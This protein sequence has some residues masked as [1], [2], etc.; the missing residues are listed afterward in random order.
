VKNR[1]NILLLKGDAALSAFREQALL[2]RLSTVQPAINA[3]TAQRVYFAA[4]TQTPNSAP[5]PTAS[6]LRTLENLLEAS[7]NG[8][9]SQVKPNPD[10]TTL[11]V[12]PR[13]GTISPWSSRATEIARHCGLGDCIERIE[14]GV[15][16]QLTA[17]VDVLDASSLESLV[18]MLHDRMT[19]S[20]LTDW[21]EIAQLFAHSEPAPM[22][23]INIKSKDGAQELTAANKALGL[24]LSEAEI[25][26]V[27]DI[28][29]KAGRAPSDVELMMF[30]QA[31]SE[32]CRHKIF[33]A[34]WVIDT[35]PQTRTLFQMIRATH[36]AQPEG[37][38]VA[39]ADNAAVIEGIPTER[40]Y[41]LTEGYRYRRETTHLVAKVETHNHPTAISPFPGAAT[42]AGGEIRDEGATGRGARPKAGLCGF[43]VS[44]LRI[45]E[46]IQPW[47]QDQIKPSHIAS[48]LEIMIAGP[49][50]AAAFNNEFGRPNL[51]GCFRTYEKA[52]VE[53][54]CVVGYYGY[55]K[56]VMLAGGVGNVASDH[57][58]KRDRLPP[59]VPLVV[60]GGPGMLIGLGGG[61]ASSLDA[62]GNT[63]ELD[64]ASVQRGNPEMQRRAQ[65]VIEQC[66]ALGPDNP[67][68]SIHDVGAGGLANAFPELAHGG[69]AG[70]CFE[71][72]KLPVEEPGM[73]PAEIWCNESQERYVLAIDDQHLEIFSSLCRRERCP[74]AVAGKTTADG[75][76]QL[77]D[78]H[79][80]N[81]PVDMPLEQ[82]L[83]KLPRQRRE[84]QRAPPRVSEIF[85]VDGLDLHEATRRVF[86]LPGVADKAF[87][88]TIGDRSVGGLT[89]RDQ[90]VGLWQVAV[91]DVAV[92]QAGYRDLH[93]EAFA[94]GERSSV[95][96]GN[97]PASGRMA[98]G[99]A[100]A[101]LVAAD[102]E[103]LRRVKLSAN[104]MAAC[105]APGE[106]ARLYDTVAAVSALCIELGIAI[107]VGKDSLSMR[108][109]WQDG[110]SPPKEVTAPLTLIVSAFATV[111]DVRR[112][113]T[114]Q[115]QLDRGETDLVLLDLGQGR[116]GGSA[117]AQVYNELGGASPDVDNPRLLVAFYAA[118]RRLQRADLLLAYHDRSDGGLL[119]STCEMAFAARCGLTLNLDS[120][121]HQTWQDDVDGG[122]KHPEVLAGA[123]HE[124]LIRALF[125]EELGAVLQI[126]ST[127]RADVTK[128]LRELG[129]P[130]YFVGSPN[131]DWSNRRNE[132]RIVRNAKTCLL[133]S[134]GELQQTWSS[135]AFHLRSMRDDPQCAAEEYE[136]ILDDNDPGLNAHVAFDFEADLACVPALCLTRPQVAVL[137]EQGVNSQQEMAAAFERAGFEPVDVHM[138]EL[139]KGEKN[140][141]TYTGLAACGGFSYGD[142]L[143]AGRGWAHTILNHERCRNEFGRFFADESRF[144]LGVC[145]GCQML[146][147]L[148]PLIPGAQYWPKFHRNRSEQYEARLTLAEISDSPSVLFT[149]MAGSRLPI[150]VSHGEGRANF[151]DDE[152]AALANVALRYV[153]HYGQVASLYPANPNGS[154]AGIA[155]LS[156]TDGRVTILMPHPERVVRNTQLSW[157][158]ADWMV[159]GGNDSPWLQVFINARRF[160]A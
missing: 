25:E 153:D 124:Q 100:L 95:A 152:S 144:T 101:N 77:F 41:A 82:L 92:T 66:I 67:I 118:I 129:V 51:A 157:H 59:G 24:A 133:V 83:G 142:V 5:S 63:A 88:I 31:N 114:P 72:R 105:G 44:N 76:L 140:L 47:E 38:V 16:Y 104:W 10:A 127:D 12:T 150:V 158:P 45:P 17:P 14:H 99:E 137:R 2:A 4:C 49:L 154:P 125:N 91:A 64:Y 98:V 68:L 11:L 86:S 27:L 117:L 94:V 40:L 143:G 93:G 160:V 13:A 141:A 126:R 42:G 19:E 108:T 69:K 61:A 134:R 34:D 113:L 138:S 130:Y 96:V 6:E 20:L 139:I 145:N 55:H 73:S 148:K 28:F 3:V 37:T 48:A 74:F 147:H 159:N 71:L 135:T 78:A 84:V 62:G 112:T 15:C 23:T 106:D 155:G 97:A 115:L 128:I 103:D 57:A 120:L 121:C 119:V 60:L 32:H 85:A 54:N 136:T 46:A 53:S 116:L 131:I 35:K 81:L 122:E 1:T 56:P 26:Y 22:R 18:P 30:A 21:S 70:A 75:H 29:Q 43:I 107:P 123:N 50:G 87:L 89:A 102:V 39:Y 80:C 79:F 9:L 8:P 149:G 36:Q 109:V 110:N 90:M 58:L 132:I 33:N 146:A 52:A 156:T 111:R 65:E 7:S 151:S